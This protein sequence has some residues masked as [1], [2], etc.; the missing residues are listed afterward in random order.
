MVVSNNGQCC[1]GRCVK[2]CGVMK[3]GDTTVLLSGS[4]VGVDVEATMLAWLSFV[5]SSVDVS[6]QMMVNV[7]CGWV[8]EVIWFGFCMGRWFRDGDI[9][10]SALFRIC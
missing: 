4:E 5:L 6:R 3:D 2:W 10:W 7:V 8:L 9:W 1:I